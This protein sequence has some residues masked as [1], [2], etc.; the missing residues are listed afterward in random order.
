MAHEIEH[1]RRR[2]NLTAA[3]H[4]FV[5]A[6]FWFH[7]LVRWM[8][9]RLIE[10]RERAC[11]ERVLEQNSRP[12]AYA[13]SI[14]KVCSF[15]MEPATA[16]VSGVSGADLKQRILRIMTHRSGTALSIGRK[17]LLIAAGLLLIAAP[18]GFGVL[19]G[20][21]GF[22]SRRRAAKGYACDAGSAEVRGRN[23]QAIIQR[24]TGGS[25]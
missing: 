25:G 24:K 19:H 20:Q 2:D 11:D 22:G 21:A 9:T 4:A 10:E 5:E 16:C 23:H 18:V 3:I 17:C 12:E 14:L 8:S 1:V 13:E 6:I 15:C 7:P